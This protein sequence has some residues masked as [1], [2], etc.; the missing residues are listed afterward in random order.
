MRSTGNV[1]Y[2]H[3]Y[4]EPRK[5]TRPRPRALKAIRIESLPEFCLSSSP[6][7]ST[8][9]LRS[10]R[11]PPSPALKVRLHVF[12]KSLR[13]NSSDRSSAARALLLSTVLLLP[14]LL[15]G[16]GSGSP[17]S[18]TL[19]CRPTQQSR[20]GA[21]LWRTM[22]SPRLLLESCPPSK[23]ASPARSEAIKFASSHTY[24]VSVLTIL[25]RKGS[26]K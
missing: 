5:V 22:P 26:C 15:S 14:T 3:H 1:N 6:L 25:S 20:S 21:R 2:L 11:S 23:E 16:P 7:Q 18:A 9:T 17:A 24:L 19:T 10:R 4:W 8:A 13:T 12:T